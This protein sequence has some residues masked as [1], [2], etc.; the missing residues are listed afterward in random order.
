MLHDTLGA[1]AAEPAAV[2]HRPLQP[3]LRV[4][5][6]GGG[7]RLAAARGPPALRGDQHARRRLPRR[8]AWTRS[9]SPAASRCCGATCRAGPDAVRQAGARRS[10]AHD[11]RHPARG[12]D[13]RSRR[14]PASAAS[15]SAST[16]SAAIASWRS[17]AST[18][19][20]RVKEGIERG[21]PRLRRASRSTPSSSRASTTTSWC[22]LIEYGKAARAPR[23]A[24]SNT[25]TSAARRSGR[26]RSVDVA[27]GDARPRSPRATDRSS[28]SASRL[29]GAGRSVRAARRH[30]VRDH[31]VDDRAVLP[32]L[33]PQPADRRR[34]VVPVPVRDATARSARGASRAAPASDELKD[35]DRG[36][37]ARPRRPRRRSPAR[38]RRAA[39]VRADQHVTA[40]SPPRNAHARRLAPSAP[41]RLCLLRSLCVVGYICSTWLT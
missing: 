27:A 8:S 24:S 7:L 17:P 2:G 25:W 9:G 4:L 31:R 20:T 32:E 22:D 23:C 36:R 29:V 33:R 13:R 28:R 10:R 14:R 26:R 35:A 19:S 1:S 38:A 39:R 18:S 16:R 11:Q 5:H 6:A 15:R 21:A 30:D 34:H 40:G 37:L 3:A 12:S 41:L